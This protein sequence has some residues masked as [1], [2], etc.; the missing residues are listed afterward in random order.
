MT[1]LFLSEIILKCFGCLFATDALLLWRIILYLMWY[2]FHVIERRALY[3]IRN[4]RDR[5]TYYSCHIACLIPTRDWTE[6]QTLAQTKSGSDL[7]YK[8]TLAW[9]R[10]ENCMVGYKW[11]LKGKT[12]N[13]KFETYRI[14]GDLVY[15]LLGSISWPF[16]LTFFIK[17]KVDRTEA[18]ASVRTEW[19]RCFPGQILPE[20]RWDVD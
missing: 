14:T 3:T 16:S 1:L 6:L 13:T 11:H 9:S 18:A 15:S 4:K 8:E 7:Q 2:S 10:K 20:R 5:N 12:A 19:A 17:S